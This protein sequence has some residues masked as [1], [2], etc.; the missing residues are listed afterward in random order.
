MSHV[1]VIYS[2]NWIQ[3]QAER[4]TTLSDTDRRTYNSIKEKQ[5]GVI[6]ILLQ[7]RDEEDNKRKLRRIAKE[8]D[9]IKN[10]LLDKIGKYAAIERDCQEVDDTYESDLKSMKAIKKL[11][12]NK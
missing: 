7:R 9:E 8:F 5:Q 10:L 6:N 2:D 12:Q 3:S 11:L 4:I 1:R